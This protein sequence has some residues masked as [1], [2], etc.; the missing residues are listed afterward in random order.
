MNEPPICARCEEEYSLHDGMDPSRYCDPCA[1][2]RVS[3][4]EVQMETLLRSLSDAGIE[5]VDGKVDASS[6]RKEFEG[7]ITEIG[8]NKTLCAKDDFNKGWNDAADSAIRFIRRYIKREGL[9]QI[10][11]PA[12]P[13]GS[14]EEVKP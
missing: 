2:E 8:A 11:L 12:P 9:F 13:T 6:V 5:V 4:L 1:Q 10:K 3:E 7:C 14:A